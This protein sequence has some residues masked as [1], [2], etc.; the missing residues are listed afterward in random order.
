MTSSPHI[1]ESTTKWYAVQCP[2]LNAEALSNVNIPLYVKAA[3]KRRLEKSSSGR[4]KHFMTSKSS[5]DMS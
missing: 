4:Q 2:A 3:R 5:Q 1:D